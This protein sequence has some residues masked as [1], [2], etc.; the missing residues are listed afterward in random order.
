MAV[1]PCGL[2][3]RVNYNDGGVIVPAVITRVDAVNN[4]VDLVQFG[5]GAAAQLRTN[6]ASGIAP[7]QYVVSTNPRGDNPLG[8]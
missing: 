1:P 6:V 3:D 4:Q 7:G 5:N 2:G 8:R